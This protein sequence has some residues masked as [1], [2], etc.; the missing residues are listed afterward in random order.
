MTDIAQYFTTN[1]EL[2]FESNQIDWHG[3]A[4]SQNSL[5]LID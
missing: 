2:I 1:D 3:M 4:D 5:M